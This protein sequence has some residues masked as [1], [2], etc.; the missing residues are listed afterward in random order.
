MKNLLI[1]GVVGLSLV[2]CA[3]TSTTY[4]P[5]RKQISEPPIGSTNTA[6]L[7][8]KLL[9]QGVMTEREA[10]YFPTAQKFTLGSTIGSGYYAK[11]RETAEYEFF[12]NGTNETGGG[13]FRDVIGMEMPFGIALRKSDNAICVTSMIGGAGGCRDGLQFEKRNWTVAGSNSFQQTLLYNGKVGNKINIAYREFSS[14]LARPAFN[15]DVEYDLSESNQIGYKGA[16]LE[17]IE[18]NNQM[19]K[20]KVIKNFN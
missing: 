5:S 10:L 13:T 18:A 19:I 14:D 1:A 20:Y 16:L 8:D 2:G 4:T 12:S 17:V 9:L 15:N 7:G 11:Q 6:S 3:T